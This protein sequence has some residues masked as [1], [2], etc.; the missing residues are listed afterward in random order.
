MG[1]ELDAEANIEN[2]FGNNGFINTDNS[3]SII[4]IATNEEW[5]IAKEAIGVV[6]E[7]ADIARH[8]KTGEH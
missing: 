4:V 3:Q 8:A 6:K 2:R 7:T 5:V 1:F